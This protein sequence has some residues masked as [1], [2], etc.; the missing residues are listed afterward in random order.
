[1]SYKKTY[2]IF[3]GKVLPPLPWAPPPLLKPTILAH[4]PKF[5]HIFVSNPSIHVYHH[6]SMSYR[7]VNMSYLLNIS[8]ITM[9]LIPTS[10]HRMSSCHV[11]L[12]Y[13]C[14]YVMSLCLCHTVI[15][16]CH[17]VIYIYTN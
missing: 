12:S 17:Y 8:R 9:D 4:R 5:I 7:H 14:R 10:S 6:Q 2:Y 15:H 13:V 3:W 16:T 11:S 1:M